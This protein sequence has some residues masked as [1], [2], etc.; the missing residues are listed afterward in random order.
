MSSRG[1]SA[2]SPTTS[3]RVD[4]TGCTSRRTTPARRS[5][6]I[7]QNDDY[8]KD[9]LY[10]F[11]AALGKKYA[12]A[13]IVAQEAVEPTATSVGGQITRIRAAGAKILAVFQLPTPTVRSIATAKALGL[14]LDQIYMNYVA[15]IKPATDGVGRVRRGGLRERDHHDRVR[16]GSAG[17][18]VGE[19]PRR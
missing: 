14:N 6:V 15:A 9:Y 10:G 12:D 13:N 7:Y 4:C 5:R 1:R 2:G 17:P 8:G 11:R 16:Q 19:R 18:E 3:P